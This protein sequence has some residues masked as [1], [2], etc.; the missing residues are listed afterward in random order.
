MGQN[1]YSALMGAYPTAILW[2][3]FHGTSSPIVVAQNLKIKMWAP[4]LEIR[5]T[6]D[7]EKAFD[8]FS[9]QATGRYLW[10]SADVKAE[11][12]KLRTDG[13]LT[14]EVLVDP[15]I[16]GGQAIQ[17][18]VDKKTDLVFNKFMDLAMKAIFDPP[19]PT[20]TAAETSSG[21][22]SAPGGAKVETTP[23]SAG[24]ALKARFDRTNLDL[25]Y[26][27]K[28]EQAFLQETTIS[29]SLEGMFE[30]MKNDPQA[31]KKYFDSV[32]P[33][34]GICLVSSRLPQHPRRNPVDGSC[35]PENRST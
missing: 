20:V 22:V 29:S 5:I 26:H 15:T 34:S 14:V 33:A 23:W 35:F 27:E 2:Q 1:A 21:T 17:E 3:A 10:F 31:E 8:H 4:L 13:T 9:G 12:N 18:T 6:G 25:E 32:R 11:M 16:P 19:P 28:R 24:L 7:W 30:E